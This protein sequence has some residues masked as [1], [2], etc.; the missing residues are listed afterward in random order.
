M[1]KQRGYIARRIPGYDYSQPGFYFVTICT[2]RRRPI[3]RKVW[4]RTVVAETM[5]GVSQE[6]PTVAVDTYVCMP[7][8][9][10]MLLQFEPEGA[11]RDDRP[12]FD[13][14]WNC[15]VAK[16]PSPIGRSFRVDPLRPTL[17]QVVRA[18][19]AVVTR[20]LRRAGIRDFAWQP[21]YFEWVVRNERA[22]NAIREYIAGNPLR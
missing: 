10:H 18:F 16:T 7:D 19:K 15:A 6:F 9:V 5:A 21:N 17:G 22:L 1:L 2:H 3:L 20:C 11:E 14:R 13:R 8:H 4:V 12:F